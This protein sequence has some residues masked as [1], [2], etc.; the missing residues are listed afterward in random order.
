VFDLGYLETHCYSVTYISGGIES[1]HSDAACATTNEAPYVFGCMDE[2]ACNYDSDANMDNGSCEYAE[3]NYDCEGNCIIDVDCAGECGG[4][5]EVDECGECGGDGIPDGECDCDGNVLDECGECGGGGIPDSACDCEGN[6]ED[7]AGVCG[8]TAEN[9]PDW[10]YDPGAYEFTSWIVVGI[11]LSEGVSLAE[12][13]DLFVALDDAGNVRGIAVQ[14]VAEFGPY[15]GQIIY[16]MT[17]GSNAEGDILSFQYYDA[18]EDLVLDVAETYTFVTN[19][20]QGDIF[21]A[22]FYNIGVT[23]TIDLIEGWNWISFNVVPEDASPGAVLE[24]VTGNK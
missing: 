3:E 12:E 11:V 10:E 14:V 20:Q 4:S 17:M 6:V 16:E 19:E 8:G 18:S 5:A 24:N 2:S 13:G 23:Q 7:C 22:V 15:Q 21:G 1:D 9:C